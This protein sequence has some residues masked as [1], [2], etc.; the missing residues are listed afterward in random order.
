MKKIT[1]CSVAVVAAFVLAIGFASV[2]D[3]QTVTT[4]TVTDAM[5][6]MWPYLNAR[7]DI[8]EGMTGAPVTALQNY[9]LST[10][11][12]S[13]GQYTQGVFDAR[14]KVGL[15]NYQSRVH[16]YNTGYFG[17]MTQAHMAIS[18]LLRARGYM[19]F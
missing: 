19:T 4:P 15:A 12:L 10:G 3:A 13:S 9:L 1:L 17:P 2:A 7:M 6:G 16:V 5:S 14:T 11:F 8:S 18:I